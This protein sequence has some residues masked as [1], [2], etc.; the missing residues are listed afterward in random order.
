MTPGSRTGGS[1]TAERAGPAKP[2]T[3]RPAARADPAPVTRSAGWADPAEPVGRCPD[4]PSG[5]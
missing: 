2:V 3:R 5:G 4:G 1:G